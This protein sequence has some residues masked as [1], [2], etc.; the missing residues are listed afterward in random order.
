MSEMSSNSQIGAIDRKH[1]ATDLKLDWKMALGN[2][3]DRVAMEKDFG[4]RGW[5]IKFQWILV[6]GGWGIGLKRF[7]GGS[8]L[9]IANS[10]R[11]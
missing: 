10:A 4:W 8:K 6:T 3:V 1:S 2:G 7:E 9:A 11:F 5:R